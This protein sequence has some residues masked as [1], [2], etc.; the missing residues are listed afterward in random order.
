MIRDA[1]KVLDGPIRQI[2]F[3][4][5]D[6]D[7]ALQSWSALGVGPWFT[8]RKL[9]QKEC[10][11][12]GALCEPTVSIAFANS[13]EMQI[14]LIQQHDTA[15]SIY[16]E[17]LEAGRE[18]F[19]QLAW[20]VAD[21][22]AVTRKADQAG[23]PAVFSGESGD[24]RFAYLELDPRVSTVVEVMELND[25]SRGLA[26]LVASAAA[27]WDGVTDPIRSLL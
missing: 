21:F 27:Q 8:I 10:R 7:A 14:E 6:L 15:P 19:H 22:D 25:A 9:Q 4:V 11:Y 23:W 24:V 12:R 2:G 13:A 20:W 26:E 18:G 5:R 16:R 17:F 1:S 3:V